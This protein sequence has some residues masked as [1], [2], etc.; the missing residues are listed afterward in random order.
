MMATDGDTHFNAVISSS[1]A[2]VER[3]RLVIPSDDASTNEVADLASPN[4]LGLAA[5]T[6]TLLKAHTTKLSLL[7]INEPYTPNEMTKI[8]K[9][10]TAECCPALV[11]CTQQAKADRYTTYLHH[12]LR[13][14]SVDTLLLLQTLFNQFPRSVSA[15]K[16]QS[17][18]QDILTNTGKIWKSCDALTELAKPSIGLR[19]VAA[20]EMR[21]LKDLLV[22]AADE[23]EEWEQSGAELLDDVSEGSQQE[24]D[25]AEPLQKMKLTATTDSRRAQSETSGDSLARLAANVAKHLRLISM[26]YPPLIK[27]RIQRFPQISSETKPEDFPS[28]TQILDLDCIMGLGRTATNLADSI[29]ESL[30]GENKEDATHQLQALRDD[31]EACVSKVANAWDGTEDEFTAWVRQW[32]AK[33]AEL[34]VEP[35]SSSQ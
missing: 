27:R 22:D 21:E 8:M 14:R 7:A 11:L 34:K 32:Q 18:R 24:T 25:I 12:Y 23:L 30:Y 26:L 6:A 19:H 15:L 33:L 17:R 9:A 5:T 4:A 29:A 35:V 1:C 13:A 10:V 3:L 28:S 20:K 31:V 2:L 16:E